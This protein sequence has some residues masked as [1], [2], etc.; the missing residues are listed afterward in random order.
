MLLVS[1]SKKKIYV[2]DFENDILKLEM[3]HYGSVYDYKLLNNIIFVNAGY[4]F[5]ISSYVE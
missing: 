5:D 3:N 2:Y 1:H 4:H